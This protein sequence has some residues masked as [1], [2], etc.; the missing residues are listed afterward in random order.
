MRGAG[1]GAGGS[2][3]IITGRIKGDGLISING[4]N[5]SVRGG[6]GGAGGRM[7]VNLL[8]S[9]MASSYPEMSHDYTGKITVAGGMGGTILANA[10]EKFV[11]VQAGAGQDG[12]IYHD[13]CF[14]GY[15]GPF[16]KA[17]DVGEFKL[18]YSFGVCKTCENK[19]TASYYT[20]RG[21][22]ISNCPYECSAGLDPF[23]VNPYCENALNAQITRVGGSTNSLLVIAGFMLLLI[24]IWISLI[25]R[26]NAIMESIGKAHSK[27]YD[28]V[29]FTTGAEKDAREKAISKKNMCM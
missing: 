6:G 27:V 15:T 16:C 11:P 14:G 13:K 5:G 4:G 12:V 10:T 7:V 19:P 29:L 1:G 18:G 21:V 8:R 26:S 28:G 17:C 24:L 25:A 3:Q 23:E 2:I 9:F 22:G 20:S